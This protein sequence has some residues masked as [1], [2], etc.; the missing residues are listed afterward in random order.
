MN[1]FG[2][3]SRFFAAGMVLT[4]LLSMLA[5][6]FRQAPEAARETLRQDTRYG[7]ERRAMEIYFNGSGRE[8]GDIS[9]QR[10]RLP[11]K[12]K[13]SLPIYPGCEDEAGYEDRVFC[14]IKRFSTFIE[15]NRVHPKG[16]ARE[17]VIVSFKIN[18]STGLMEALQVRRCKDHRNGQEALRVLNL[19]V[20]R[21]VRWS[22][23]TKR[24]EPFDIEL[25]I[26]VSFHGARCGE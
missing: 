4:L 2:L 21:K 20:E 10:P 6:G 7:H 16:S 11:P 24:G 8:C 17:Q 14:G 15:T 9:V 19:L 5:W 18:K 13:L 23:A 3:N 22:P 12:E 25:G 1:T 26:P